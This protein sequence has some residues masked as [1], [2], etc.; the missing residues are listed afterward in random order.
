MAR[1]SYPDE[2]SVSVDFKNLY[3]RNK[4]KGYK[5][6]NIHKAMSHSPEVGL[7]LLRLGNAI[8]LKSVVPKKLRELAILRVGNLCS[9]NY[10]WTQHLPIALL[11]G[12]RQVQ[13][14]ALPHWRNSSEFDENEKAV[15]QYT[16]EVTLNVRVKDDTFAA[17]RSFLSEEAIVELTAA[18]S[19]YGMICRILET[20]QIELEKE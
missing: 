1:I 18:V 11:V 15:L 10:E 19:Y 12:V 13:I 3:Q 7:Q 5:I 17:V 14:N 8:L 6:L 2:E 16:D 20:L 9:A 4:E